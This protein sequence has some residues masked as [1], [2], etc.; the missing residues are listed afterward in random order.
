MKDFNKHIEIDDYLDGKMTSD[1]KL[2]FEAKVESDSV[3]KN[4]LELQRAANLLVI[5]SAGFDLKSKLKNIHEQEK[6]QKAKQKAGKKANKIIIVVAAVAAIAIVSSVLLQDTSGESKKHQSDPS[7]DKI[8]EKNISYTADNDASKNINENIYKYINETSSKKQSGNLNKDDKAESKNSSNSE[9]VE[10]IVTP[11]TI[12]E[13]L[14]KRNVEESHGDESS[15]SDSGNSGDVGYTNEMLAKDD[16]KGTKTA[17]VPIPEVEERDT[18]PCATTNKIK[19]ETIVKQPCFGGREGSLTLKSNSTV[20]LVEFSIDGGNEFYS[21]I[22]SPVVT[23]G[24]YEVI[25][26]DEASCLTT[27]NIIKVTDGSCPFIIQSTALE[28]MDLQIP[29]S[30]ESFIFEVRNSRSGEVVYTEV[31]EN[32]SS[33]TYKGVDRNN[34]DLALGSYSYLITSLDSE[35]IA[36][37]LITVVR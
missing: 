11:K 27:K 15:N 29:T 12:V 33:Y 21:A 35:F 7:K 16:G 31:I 28:F 30:S 32:S 20:N 25:G 5:G 8:E 19:P 37:G 1:Q 24:L 3:F 2:S 36:K 6:K 14:P 4:E 17:S 22:E 13:E 10:D 23:S 34:R 26:R 18:N 9:A